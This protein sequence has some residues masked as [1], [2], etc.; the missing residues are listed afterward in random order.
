MVKLPGF[1]GGEGHLRQNIPL[2]IVWVIQL[3]VAFIVL[4]TSASY[5]ADFTDA[6]C[7]VPAK[8][9]YNVACVSELLLSQP[10]LSMHKPSRD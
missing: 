2:A 9:G 8:I 6:G 7:N 3:L 4:G 1:L 10:D 5:A